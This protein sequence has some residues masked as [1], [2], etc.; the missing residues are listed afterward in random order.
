MTDS[1]KTTVVLIANTSWYLWN[2]RRRLAAEILGSGFRLIFVAPQDSY[3]ARLGEI[4]TYVP[5]KLS[6]QGKNP[7]AELLAIRHLANLFSR[8]RPDVV[9]SW[10]PKLNIYCGLISR[11][12]GFQLIPNVAG[13]GTVFVNDSLLAKLVGILYR[14]AFAKLNSVFF[15][16]QDDMEVFVGAGWLQR[17]AAS[18]LP[19]SGVDLSRFR[20]APPAR[21]DPFLFLY[22]GRLLSEK[23]LPELVDASRQLRLDGRSFVLRVCGHLDPG[24]PSGVC[25]EQI[26]AWRNAGLIEYYGANDRMEIEIQRT[27]CV[28]LPS[29]YREGIPRILLEAAACGR[30]VITT[31][32]VGCREAVIDG[33]TGILCR[34]RDI[35]SLVSAMRRMLDLSNEERGEMGLAAHRLAKARFSEDIVVEKYLKAIRRVDAL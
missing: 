3:S 11:F 7:I 17:G 31:D 25:G 34:P 2:F 13:L 15:Q 23:G 20:R 6:R 10:T 29:Y 19:G 22:G 16:N 27:N 26:A 8:E 12:S 14:L 24:N 35:P 21:N 5:I 9:L 32:S 30:P 1:N 18:L 28:V 33:V 4:S